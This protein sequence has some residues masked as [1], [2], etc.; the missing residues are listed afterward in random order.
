MTPT[1]VEYEIGMNVM[2][3][4]IHIGQADQRDDESSITGLTTENIQKMLEA[5]KS[6]PV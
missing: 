4:T 1:R 2:C 3:W 6:C 5:A